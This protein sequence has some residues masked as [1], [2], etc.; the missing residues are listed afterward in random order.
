MDRQKLSKEIIGV[1]QDKLFVGPTAEV[2]EEER[3]VEDL[4][5]DS[6]DMIEVIFELERRYGIS[7]T[8]EESDRLC[9]DEFTVAEIIDFTYKKIQE[10]E[11]ERKDMLRHDM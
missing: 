4:G 1:I 2:H 11:A 5:G 10:H 8:D 9:H 3:F 7:I 6:L